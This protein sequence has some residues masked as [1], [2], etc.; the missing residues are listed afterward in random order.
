MLVHAV[1]DLLAWLAAAGIGLWVRRRRWLAQAS[2]L[3]LRRNPGYVI[4][5]STGALAGALL[6]GSLNLDLAGQ[7]LLGHSIG[8]AILGGIVAIEIFKRATGIRGSTGLIFVAPL[9]LGIAV[10]RWG[11]F[12][13][14]V[15]DY[16]YGIPTGLPWGV[17]FGDGIPRHPVQLY[18]SF[19]MLAFLIVFLAQVAARSAFFLRHGFYL[20][21]A[22]YGAQRFVWEFLKPYPAVAGPF[23]LFHL[24]CIALVAYSALMLRQTHELR[25]AG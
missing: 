16:T 12:F 17:D 6:F 9:A 5:L 24:L 7:S 25:P 20:F 8:G 2:P 22:C 21:V 1:F 15:P 18:E 23:N 19:A 11:C 10:G 13:A 4:A 14:G 3:S